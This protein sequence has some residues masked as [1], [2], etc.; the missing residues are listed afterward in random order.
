MLLCPKT[1]NT[2]KELSTRWEKTSGIAYVQ[3]IENAIRCIVRSG[4]KGI[5]LSM[6][7]YGHV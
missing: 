4:C 6:V 1:W 5:A 3:L 7:K 2:T